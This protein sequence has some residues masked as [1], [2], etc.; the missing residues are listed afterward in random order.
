MPKLLLVVGSTREGR[1]GRVIADWFLERAQELGIAEWSVAD[2]AELDLPWFAS[3]KSPAYAGPADDPAVKR[4]A[5]MVQESDGFAWVASEY[6]H[7]YA[8]PLKNAIDH[9]YKEWVRKPVAMVTYGGYAGGARA[10]EQLRQVA[11]ELQMAPIRF[12]VHLPLPLGLVTPEGALDVPDSLAASVGDTVRDLVWWAD[13]L[14]T[15]REA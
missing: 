9:L 14:K 12:G 1:R 7:G 11:V 13:A 5:A 4:W 8:A 10:A 3:A 2:L 6:N 15:A